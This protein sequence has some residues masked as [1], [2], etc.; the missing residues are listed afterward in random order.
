[1]N[2]NYGLPV[3]SKLHVLIIVF[4]VYKKY[5]YRYLLI[6]MVDEGNVCQRAIYGP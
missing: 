4:I 1:M 6:L 5:F 3:I 2:K